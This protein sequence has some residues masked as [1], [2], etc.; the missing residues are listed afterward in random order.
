MGAINSEIQKLLKNHDVKEGSDENHPLAL[1]KQHINPPHPP[2]ASVMCRILGKQGL[3]AEQGQGR[4]TA[5]TKALGL[6]W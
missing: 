3:E 2:V 6:Q 5:K 1:P 4:K